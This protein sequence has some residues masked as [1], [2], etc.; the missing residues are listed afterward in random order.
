MT[1]VK[2]NAL[3]PL[4]ITKK[5]LLKVKPADVNTSTKKRYYLTNT[6]SPRARGILNSLFRKTITQR[7]HQSTYVA[8]CYSIKTVG[9]MIKKTDCD[10]QS[11]ASY[12]RRFLLL[13]KSVGHE[14]NAI[15]ALSKT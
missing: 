12:A 10:K 7:Q 8:L 11:A 15:S 2:K 13:V 9:D 4:Q 5:H 1:A 14:N 6:G 3:S